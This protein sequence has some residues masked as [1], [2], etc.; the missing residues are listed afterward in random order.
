M[1]GQ[2][3]K[4]ELIAILERDGGGYFPDVIATDP[5]RH[6]RVRRLLENAFTARRLKQLEPAFARVVA[7]LVEQV[8][9]RGHAD[10]AAFVERYKA[11]APF[12][13]A[14]LEDVLNNF[15]HVVDLIGI[16]K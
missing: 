13:Y 5:P 1:W 8:A 2:G 6:G 7:E 9:D 10:V 15:D 14:T 11:D 4:E 16:E 12:V 3:F